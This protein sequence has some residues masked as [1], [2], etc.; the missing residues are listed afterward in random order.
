M[1]AKFGALVV[2]GRGKLN[3]WVASRNRSGAYF[4]TKVSPVNPST[5]AQ[6]EARDLL[7][8]LAAGWRDL[9]EAQRASFNGAVSNFAKT[10]IFGDLRNP[11][12]FNLYMR[13]NA[14]LSLIGE[15]L[16]TSAP[17]PST[18]GSI[19]GLSVAGDSSSSTLA[20]TFTVADADTSTA[21]V[22]ATPGL[23]PGKNFAK[24][25]Y[26]LIAT[27]GA[28]PASPIAAGGDW[29]TKFGELITG[30]KIFVKIVL[31]NAITGQASPG[32]EASTIVVA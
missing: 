21:L 2:E 18:P 32:L 19:S 1:K 30:Q 16:L 26:R 24:S 11:S 6:S 3:G 22:Y 17:L 29:E 7:A 9:T 8:S 15:A 25:E 13:L 28:P 20:I 27:N 14:N 5:P 10:D 23:S 31:I 4:R 12:G